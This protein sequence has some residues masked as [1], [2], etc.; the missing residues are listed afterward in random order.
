MFGAGPCQPGGVALRTL[1]DFTTK[2]QRNLDLPVQCSVE[3]TLSAMNEIEVPE[4]YV[5]G[6]R[7]VHL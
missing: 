7:L 6:I 2:G 4:R 1:Y 3:G 5:H